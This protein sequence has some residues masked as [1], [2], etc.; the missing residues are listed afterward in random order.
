MSISEW[1]RILMTGTT[2]VGNFAFQLEHVLLFL[3][4]SLLSLRSLYCQSRHLQA[5]YSNVLKYSQILSTDW[6]KLV[7]W[8]GRST[9]MR[10]CPPMVQACRSLFE[11]H[12]DSSTCSVEKE[13]DLF[14]HQEQMNWWVG[15]S[16]AACGQFKWPW[17]YPC[18]DLVQLQACGEE[19]FK[20]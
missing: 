14:I 1:P 16:L 15:T 20:V 13:I 5:A 7:K 19:N 3:R 4:L 11:E 18:N 2:V 9:C 17:L 10:L 6:M 12:L 8:K